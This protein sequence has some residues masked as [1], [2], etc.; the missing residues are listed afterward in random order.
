MPPSIDKDAIKWDA[1]PAIDP[2][3]VQWDAAPEM[4]NRERF[5]SSLPVRFLRGVEGPAIVALKALGPES[6]KASLTDIDALRDSG[7]KKRG[8]EG[9]NWAG[10][11]GSLV[12]GGAIGKGI[13][14]AL[15]VATSALGKIASG[16]LVGGAT[17]GAVPVSGGEEL[18]ADKLKQIGTG[19]AIGGLFPA[20]GAGVQKLIG[21]ASS[22]NPTKAAT[23][24]EGRQYGY[25]VP[26]SQVN[27]SPMNNTM[28]TISGKASLNQ[29]GS[30]K[31][32]DITNALAARALGL[33][34]ETTI[35][36]QV[37][38]ASGAKAGKVFEEAKT[39][40]PTAQWAVEAWKQAKSDARVTFNH[41][42]ANKDPETL[43]KAKSFRDMSDLLFNEIENESVKAGKP[44]LASA[45]KDASL[46]IAKVEQVRRALNEADSNVSA[47]V[48][49]KMFA[50]QSG[51]GMTG[52]LATIGKM[53][54]AFPQVM[55]EGAK[56]PSPAVSGTDAASSA[57]LGA[58]GFGAAGP[59]GSALAALPLLRTPA[60][61]L[62]V[63]GPFQRMATEGVSPRAQAMIDALMQH[64]AAAG[65]TMAGRAQGG[66]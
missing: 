19:A 41:Y 5:E 22:I 9:T 40:S 25:A 60:R 17:S 43:A 55:A 47:R 23:L 56:V 35:I 65:G 27:P 10:L 42:N 49:G 50:K 14:G 6:M 30:K 37:L 29:L 15:P 20:M 12:P 51:K 16:A 26:P 28:E 13:S 39:I 32:Q 21:N 34:N 38:D 2:S 54:N 44:E 8:D 18:S 66:R 59:A 33:P 7:M 53:N 48:L 52:E 3:T 64:G 24:A 46:H 58:L 1:A 61:H 63:S 31:N 4:T 57:I 62:I 11:L 36:P 45:L